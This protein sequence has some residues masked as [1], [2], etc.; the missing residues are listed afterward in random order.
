MNSLEN[1]FE[2]Q[3]TQLYKSLLLTCLQKMRRLNIPVDEISF[4]KI[5]LFAS[6]LN[7][8][9]FKASDVWLNKLK[10]LNSFSFKEL[11]DKNG[12]ADT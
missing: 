1:I 6:K 8:K 4:K 9:G 7:I 2:K 12:T 10:F 3:N 11:C 5:S